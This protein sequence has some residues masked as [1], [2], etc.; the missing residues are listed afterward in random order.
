MTNIKA[1]LAALSLL[2]ACGKGEDPPS[3]CR[4]SADCGQ[5]LVC[6]VSAG[7]GACQ[8]PP[9]AVAMTAPAAGARVGRLGVPCRP[10]SRRPRRTPRR[11]PRW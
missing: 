2:A 1:S 3:E 7:A 8:S 4:T 9:V 10:G 5:G 6:I 11:R